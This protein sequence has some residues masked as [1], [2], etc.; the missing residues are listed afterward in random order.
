MGK[1]KNM[2]KFNMFY[3]FDISKEK[4]IQV[5]DDNTISLTKWDNWSHYGQKMYNKTTILN[6]NL[7][8][9]KKQFLSDNLKYKP[10][11]NADYKKLE[12]S[13]KEKLNIGKYLIK[14]EGLK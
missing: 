1:I 9:F 11:R 4:Q 5:S 2:Q 14:F 8:Q 3:P 7:E 13:D 10:K 6:I 12:L